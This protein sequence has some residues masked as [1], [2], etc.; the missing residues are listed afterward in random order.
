MFKRNDQDCAHHKSGANANIC[1]ELREYTTHT[2][3][4]RKHFSAKH[5]TFMHQHTHKLSEHTTYVSGEARRENSRRFT[6][7]PARHSTQH[8]QHMHRRRRTIKF[9]TFLLC[10]TSREIY[11]YMKQVNIV[12]TKIHATLLYFADAILVKSFERTSI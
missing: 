10:C 7:F 8:I 12:S 5:Q 6:S 11:I 4:L 2:I 9:L 3:Q 1:I